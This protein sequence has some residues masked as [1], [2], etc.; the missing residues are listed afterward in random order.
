MNSAKEYPYSNTTHTNNASTTNDTDRHTDGEEYPSDSDSEM[1]TARTGTLRRN[2]TAV[3][4]A[5]MEEG[6]TNN[7]TLPTPLPMDI[8]SSSE[9][10]PSE[11]SSSSNDSDDE[12]SSSSSSSSKQDSSQY[13]SSN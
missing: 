11:R 5:A 3:P 8:K 2:S 1:D 4:P 7:N 13:S 9:P 12:N 10:S 6:L